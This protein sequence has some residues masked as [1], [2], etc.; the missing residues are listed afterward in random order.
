MAANNFTKITHPTSKPQM[1][2]PRVKLRLQKKV[3]LAL[4][5]VTNYSRDKMVGIT[6]KAY[7]LCSNKLLLHTVRFMEAKVRQDSITSNKAGFRTPKP[8]GFCLFKM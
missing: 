7:F 6:C 8:M 2:Q 1:R 3:S 5:K 4:I